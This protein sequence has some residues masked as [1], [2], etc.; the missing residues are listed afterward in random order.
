MARDASL[1]VEGTALLLAHDS[2][3]LAFGRMNAIV[4][5]SRRKIPILI[6]VGCVHDEDSWNSFAIR[7]D[8]EKD[9]VL[10]RNREERKSCC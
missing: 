1:V 5:A 10:A 7:Y 8:D 6:R 9:D 2:N 4:A 3:A